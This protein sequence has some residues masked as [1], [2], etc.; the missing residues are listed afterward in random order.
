MNF[1]F[2]RETFE[3]LEE[4]AEGAMENAEPGAIM[5]LIGNKSELKTMYLIL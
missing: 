1:I 4:W 5:I 2:S 3:H